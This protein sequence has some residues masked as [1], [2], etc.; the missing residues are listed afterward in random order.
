[1]LSTSFLLTIEDVIT[2]SGRKVMIFSK[3]AS[4]IPPISSICKAASG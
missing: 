3:L 4:E 2:I 1:M